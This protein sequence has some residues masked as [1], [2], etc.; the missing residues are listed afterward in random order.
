ML[1]FALTVA[2][3][4]LNVLLL[5]VILRGLIAGKRKMSGRMSLDCA[6]LIYMVILVLAWCWGSVFLFPILKLFD[7]M[8]FTD[9]VNVN[10]H[11]FF[12]NVGGAYMFSG[13]AVLVVLYKLTWRRLQLPDEPPENT[14][15]STTAT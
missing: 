5:L 13:I 2:T 14:D 7:L 1:I 15:A 12:M 9:G 11:T 3:W 8:H 6:K 10:G 4:T